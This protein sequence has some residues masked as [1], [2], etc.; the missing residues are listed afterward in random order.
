MLKGHSHV[1]F[2]HLLFE[3]HFES[4]LWRFSYRSSGV[5]N[6]V[7]FKIL[8]MKLTDWTVLCPTQRVTFLASA[9][10]CYMC[11][12]V[13]RLTWK[14]TR[15]QWPRVIGDTCAPGQVGRTHDE[16]LINEAAE[17]H[18]SAMTT[19]LFISASSRLTPGL[20]S[21]Q[22]PVRA[23]KQSRREL[24]G[25]NEWGGKKN[26]AKKPKRIS[27]IQKKSPAADSARFSADSCT[28][29]WHCPYP[30]IDKYVNNY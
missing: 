6:G 22:P 5:T 4:V 27:W 8:H 7:W 24:H 2:N 28:P 3:E 17:K 20:Y 14:I 18:H 21:A 13:C 25:D 16:A 23:N 29:S 10:R 12:I 11:S 1:S 30:H 15:C 19:V 9:V 26:P